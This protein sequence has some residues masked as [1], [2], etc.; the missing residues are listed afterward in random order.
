MGK[1]MT[2][3]EWDWAA[4]ALAMIHRLSGTVE[5]ATAEIMK[6]HNANYRPVP[7]QFCSVCHR[8]GHEPFLYRLQEDQERA[9]ELYKQLMAE[10]KTR[11]KT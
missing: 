9:T 3:Q 11:V 10:I 8:D 5:Q 4:R 2:S 7:G 6:H 1:A